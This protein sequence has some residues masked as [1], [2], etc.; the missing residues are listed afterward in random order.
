MEGD[1]DVKFWADL[2]GEAGPYP[3]IFLVA[4]AI[5]WR[6]MKWLGVRA[7]KVIDGHMTLVESLEKS[8][9]ATAG[10]I[11]ASTEKLIKI[12]ITTEAT[13]DDVEKLL[14][15]ADGRR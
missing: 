8:S 13:R 15:R 11:T 7:D 6:V 14:E 3:V 12:E 5:A 1:E 2:L 4:G 10:A 9:T